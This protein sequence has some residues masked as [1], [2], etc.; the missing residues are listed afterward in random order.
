MIAVHVFRGSTAWCHRSN[1]FAGAALQVSAEMP[2][3][4]ATV[5]LTLFGPIV[6]VGPGPRLAASLSGPAALP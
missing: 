3:L 5:R 2:V 1:V 6:R 4:R